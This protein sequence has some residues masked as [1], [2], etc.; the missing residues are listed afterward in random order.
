MSNNS[1][2]R[3]TISFDAEGKHCGH[4]MIPNQR[5]DAALSFLMIP[6]VSIRN[7]N[8]PVVFLN[9]GS[10]GD[11]F[12]GQ[13]ALRDLARNL[14]HSDI[15]GQLIIIPSLNLPSVE[16]SR[17][18][19]PIDSKDLNR[20]FPGTENGTITEKIASFVSKE[21][22]TRADVVIDLHAG[23]SSVEACPHIMIHGRE[24]M[25]SDAIFSTTVAA[26][27]AFGL[28]YTF[29]VD[30]P[31][32]D[33]MLDTEV[34]K[35][36]KPFLCVEAG[37]GG[38]TSAE[39]VLRTKQGVQNLLAF[40]KLV[41]AQDDLDAIANRCAVKQICDD[42]FHIAP[43]DGFLEHM[44]EHGDSVQKGDVIGRIHDIHHV[45]REPIVIKAQCAGQ[46]VVRRM[47]TLTR[48]GD[49]I[50]GLAEPF[51]GADHGI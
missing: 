14:N 19:S 5:D 1:N 33:G 48:S 17:R 21:I 44:V 16:V 30:F 36:G 50:A 25:Q 28:D 3:C 45:L 7:G 24:F 29:I 41:N 40:F 38:Q 15:D 51:V 12:E 42:G 18:R 32:R 22:V 27:K 4:I 13:I 47:P 2:F 35:A 9:A 8:G 37:S 6:I 11:E 34:E 49:F 31:D 20:S 43:A 26:A 39:T 46:L 10:H 23:G